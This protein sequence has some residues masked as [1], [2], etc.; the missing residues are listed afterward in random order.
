M[1]TSLVGM[2]RITLV[3]PTAKLIDNS[4]YKIFAHLIPLCPEAGVEMK[5]MKY[6]HTV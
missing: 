6:K 4:V 2:N 5:C 3:S 1:C